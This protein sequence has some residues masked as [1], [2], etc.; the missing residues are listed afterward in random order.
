MGLQ[1]GQAQ[2]RQ[3]GHGVADPVGVDLERDAAVVLLDVNMPGL[4]GLATA[5]ALR[6]RE[7][8][9]GAVPTP[10]IF[11]TAGDA[12]DRERLAAAYA[13]GAVDLIGKPFDPEALIES[14]KAVLP[15]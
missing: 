13:L 9:A 12:T 2:P 5:R 3:V 6:E 7:R 11:L 10:V 1:R 4:D 14:T 8:A 15:V